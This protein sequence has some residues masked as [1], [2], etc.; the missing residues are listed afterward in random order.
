MLRKICGAN[1][2]RVIAEWKKFMTMT[3]MTCASEQILLRRGNQGV[4]DGWNMWHA[5][6]KKKVKRALVWKSEEEG[7]LWSPKGRWGIILKYILKE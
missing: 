5:S 1:Y 6:K 4:W 7:P 3:S 2:V